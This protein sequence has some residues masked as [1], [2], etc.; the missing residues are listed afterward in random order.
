MP[1]AE[2]GEAFDTNGRGA[3]HVLDEVS[4]VMLTQEEKFV[5]GR[6][7]RRSVGRGILL[8]W[9]RLLLCYRLP[10]MRNAALVELLLP[11]SPM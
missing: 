11:V 6:N 5:E 2:L 1:T 7:G 9:L 3:F 4:R 10:L 8:R